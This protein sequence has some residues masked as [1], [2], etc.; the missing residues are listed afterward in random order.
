[1]W[2]CVCVCVCVSPL[3]LKSEDILFHVVA[4]TPARLTITPY[5]RLIV[6]IINSTSRLTLLCSES[7]SMFAP[8][9]S[10]WVCE[11]DINSGVSVCLCSRQRQTEGTRYKVVLL[12]FKKTKIM[13]ESFSPMYY[14]YF[15]DNEGLSSGVSQ[16]GE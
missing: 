10:S 16:P 9:F 7:P 13:I 15:L 12:S 2:V 11:I 1:M 5:K 4:N 3:L 8:F 14:I 6:L